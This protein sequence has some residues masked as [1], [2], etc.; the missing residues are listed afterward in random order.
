MNTLEEMYSADV[1]GKPAQ[2]LMQQLHTYLQ[3]AYKE[4]TPKV[5]AWE[6]PKQEYQ[7][8]KQFLT[9][10]DSSKLFQEVLD[11][12][13]HIHHPKYIGHQVAPIVPFGALTAAVSA[14]LNNG[15]AV[16]EMG[17]A[18]TAMERVVAE[19]MATQIG[20]SSKSR[21]IFTSG[22][23][24]G[25]LTA[26]LTARRQAVSEDIWNQGTSKQ[27]GIM[28]SAQA[29]YSVDRAV[30][31]MGMGEQGTVKIP[32]TEHFVLDI[33]QLQKS[34]DRAMAEGIEIFAIVGSAP[35]TATGNYDNLEAVAAF[36]QKHQLWFH[37]DG[38]HGA[39]AIFSDRYKTLLKGIE[40]ADSIIID[41]HKMMMMP[42][43][44]TAVL[45][46]EGVAN[47]STFSQEASYLLEQ[48]E[49]E[50][51]YNLAKRTFECT[52]N[53]M[54]LHWYAMIQQYGK[55]GFA[56]IVDR[57]YDMG[58][59]MAKIIETS[60]DFEL[61]VQPDSNIV[62]F[63]FVGAGRSDEEHNA[64]NRKIRRALLDDGSFYIVAT[65]LNDCFYL[66]ITIMNIFTDQSHLQQLLND[67]RKAAK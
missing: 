23:T 43:L 3:Q 45:Y 14:L 4:Q 65:T 49:E 51:W 6:E 54:I 17:K 64:C 35:S 16:Y 11:R 46:K 31:I 8:W 61:A 30:R 62:C 52:K 1:L 29:H 10:G 36:A 55:Q 40:Q 53:M 38:A 56:A 42:A 57:L 20:Y 21:G 67:I 13:I 33:D 24:L 28:V 47:Y 63:R 39:A 12:S 19:W 9:Q 7:F 18:S 60:S 37:V 5:L 27:Y 2:E 32:V 34:Y 50:D 48:S 58:K 59:T 25:T 44:T 66:R 15:M 22:G 26:L 41:G